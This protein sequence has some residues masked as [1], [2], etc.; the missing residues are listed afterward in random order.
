MT[1]LCHYQTLSTNSETL[2]CNDKLYIL[3]GFRKL[4]KD[5]SFEFLCQLTRFEVINNHIVAAAHLFGLFVRRPSFF[6]NLF[7]G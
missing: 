6:K 7:K 4:M 5:S 2:R 3:V 1:I